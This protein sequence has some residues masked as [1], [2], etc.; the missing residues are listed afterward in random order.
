[1]GTRRRLATLALLLIASGLL[2]AGA[3]AEV[4]QSGDVRVN[5]QA[6]FAPT[7]LPRERPAPITVTVGGRISTTN[8]SHPPPL[9]RMRIELNSAGRI[10]AHGLPACTAALLQS[11]STTA[12]T[13]RCH[14]AQ[15]G[16]GTFQAQLPLAG[17]PLAVD[18]RALVFNGLV[19]GRAGMLIHV[20]IA[21]PVRVTLVIPLKISRR[22]GQFGTVLTTKV[23]TLAGGFG[24]ITELQLRIGRDYTYRGTRRSYLSAACAAPAGF[25]GALFS[26][27]RGTFSFA[28]GRTLHTVLNRNCKVRK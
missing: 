16:T 1:M 12:A 24:S 26:F 4:I 19:D 11:T 5:F 22:G 18:G 14:A 10:E 13:A 8:G 28:G 7:S 9:R 21:T 6:D 25:P 23:P 15:V 27:A 2:A 17:K 3:R 20:Y